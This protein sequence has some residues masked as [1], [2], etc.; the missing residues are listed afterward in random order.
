MELTLDRDDYNRGRVMKLK[1][2]SISTEVDLKLTLLSKF[3]SMSKSMILRSLVKRFTQARS[4]RQRRKAMPE[5]FENTTAE[6]IKI[7]KMLL[8]TATY[9]Y[10]LIEDKDT[11]ILYKLRASRALPEITK[12]I[13]SFLLDE[14]KYEELKAEIDALMKAEEERRNNR[15]IVFGTKI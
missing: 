7:F 2:Y 11:D 13:R 3:Y 12:V 10:D 6:R 5:P 15:G 14:E 9:L 4:R 8:S 1:T